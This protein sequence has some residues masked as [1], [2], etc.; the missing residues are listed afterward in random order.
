MWHVEHKLETTANPASVWRRWAEVQGWP[1]WDNSLVWVSFRGLL[2]LGGK[3]KI[4]F[5]SGEILNF[6]VTEFT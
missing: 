1:D 4:K 5:R 6:R 2:M 3:G